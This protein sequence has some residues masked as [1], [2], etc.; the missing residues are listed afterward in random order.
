[1]PNSKNRFFCEK[2]ITTSQVL[3]ETKVKPQSICRA[4]IIVAVVVGRYQ[5]GLERRPKRSRS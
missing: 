2:Q 5:G 1:M 3:K 4:L